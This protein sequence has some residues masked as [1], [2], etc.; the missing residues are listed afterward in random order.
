MIELC[1]AP[2]T[3]YHHLEPHTSPLY[4]QITTC[5]T[6]MLSVLSVLMLVGSAMSACTEPKVSASSYTPSDSQVLTAIPFIAEFSLACSNG[7]QPSLYAD[8]DGNL[9]PVTKAI[10]GEK[11]Q[12]HPHQPRT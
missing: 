5:N 8:I 2:Q 9:V 12:V 3:E 10:E 4:L 7:V 1:F 6:R 11:Y